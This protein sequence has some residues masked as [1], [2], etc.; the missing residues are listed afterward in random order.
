[1][2]VSTEAEECA[3]TVS[4]AIKQKV[5]QNSNFLRRL[6]FYSEYQKSEID[7]IDKEKSLNCQN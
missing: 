6:W 7:L 5:F 4:S 3:K 1:M 2:I